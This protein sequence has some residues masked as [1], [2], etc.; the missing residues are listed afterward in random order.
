MSRYLKALRHDPFFLVSCIYWFWVLVLLLPSMALLPNANTMVG[1]AAASLVLSFFG[2]VLVAHFNPTI[3]NPVRFL[4]GV[5]GIS[6]AFS[7]AGAYIPVVHPRTFEIELLAFDRLLFGTSAAEFFSRWNFLGLNEALQVAYSTYYFLPL[8][9]LLFLMAKGRHEDL[10]YFILALVLGF[11]ASFVLYVMVP[12]RSP[13]VVDLLQ[14][15]LPAV[16]R[17]FQFEGPLELGPVGSFI[18]HFLDGVE[19]NKTD[20]FPSGHTGLSLIS[21]VHVARF[22]PRLLPL[23]VAL[24]GSIMVA[25]LH[26]RYHY[27]LDLVAGIFLC[28]AVVF[29]VDRIRNQKV[30]GPSHLSKGE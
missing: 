30:P 21:L 4:L 16:A 29:V 7:L 8:P 6:V 17:T 25:T 18:R 15:G 23:Y 14:S 19:A 5:A 12:A 3:R 2:P 27:V 9:P 11:Y 1:T 24:V 28:A 26:L 10:E 22:L 20:C 13:Y